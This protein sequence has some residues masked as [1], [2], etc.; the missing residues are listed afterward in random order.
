MIKKSLFEELCIHIDKAAAEAAAMGG[1]DT[2]RQLR[3]VWP[4]ERASRQRDW[5][6]PLAW[7][8][9]PQE[10]ERCRGCSTSSMT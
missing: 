6:T 9:A 1:Q 5:S 3:A 7:P 2:A 10:N 4:K 8:F